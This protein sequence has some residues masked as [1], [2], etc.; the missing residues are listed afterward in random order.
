MIENKGYP[1]QDLVGL[2]MVLG[3]AQQACRTAG[4]IMAPSPVLQDMRL[5]GFWSGFVPPKSSTFAVDNFVRNWVGIGCGA[6]R[7]GPKDKLPHF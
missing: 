2:F 6:H 1:S 5:G 3:A 7:I 4:A